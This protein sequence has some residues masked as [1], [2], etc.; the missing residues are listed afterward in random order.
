MRITGPILSVL[1]CDICA[2]DNYLS[3]AFFNSCDHA[4]ICTVRNVLRGLYPIQG[5]KRDI[6]CD[7]G[8][9][10]TILLFLSLRQS[11]KVEALQNYTWYL[12][13]YIKKLFNCQHRFFCTRSCKIAVHL[14]FL[15]THVLSRSCILCHL[16]RGGSSK[17][18]DTLKVSKYK[19]T[20]KDHTLTI[21]IAFTTMTETSMTKRFFIRNMRLK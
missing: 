10:P 20:P 19:T 11:I 7:G 16:L 1:P 13:F 17:F 8:H 2:R 15:R 4:L 9:N 3:C 14:N 21:T 6:S 12:I 5:Y 18:S